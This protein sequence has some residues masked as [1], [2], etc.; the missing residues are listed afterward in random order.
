METI[1]AASP[2]VRKAL[3]SQKKTSATTL[4]EHFGPTG[5][6]Q[7]HLNW[8]SMS[9][10]CVGDEKWDRLL[11]IWKESLHRL[12]LSTIH[13]D[14]V[15]RMFRVA[16]LVESLHT[17]VTHFLFSNVSSGHLWSIYLHFDVHPGERRT[18]KWFTF[19]GDFQ[20][21]PHYFVIRHMTRKSSFF[22]GTKEYINDEIREVPGVLKEAHMNCLFTSL[23]QM[24]KLSGSPPLN[25]SVPLNVPAIAL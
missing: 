2:E 20:V 19:H 1:V 10:T 22:S 14:E 9:G 13:E 8:T 23:N 11:V 18:F 21:A 15:N 16:A 5:F 24:L 12:G 6:K 4:E 7:M 3:A 17:G 25:P